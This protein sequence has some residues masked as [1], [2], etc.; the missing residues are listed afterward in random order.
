MIKV[1]LD[2]IMQ[3]LE[4]ISSFI[5][6]LFPSE[7]KSVA[8]VSLL[9]MWMVLAHCCYGHVWT[10]S[11]FLNDGFLEQF[12]TCRGV[13]PQIRVRQNLSLHMVKCRC[14][15]S[16]AQVSRHGLLIFTLIVMLLEAI[17]DSMLVDMFFNVRLG[18]PFPGLISIERHLKINWILIS[19]L[20]TTQWVNIWS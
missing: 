13:L 19:N 6:I 11:F 5:P 17:A 12:N 1:V 2:P 10:F 8:A 9:M 20:S 15:N 7:I 4:W 14:L 16:S 3:L 18:I